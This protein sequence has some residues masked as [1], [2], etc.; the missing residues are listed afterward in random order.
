MPETTTPDPL[1]A[2]PPGTYAAGARSPVVYVYLCP[3]CAGYA[4]ISTPDYSGA[5]SGQ[6]Q[7]CGS[8]CRELHRFPALINSAARCQCRGQ[9][10]RVT[11]DLQAG[12]ER[13]LKLVARWE[14]FG[15][16][17]DAQSECA[18]ELREAISSELLG[19]KEVSSDGND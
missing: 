4:P 9:H 1:A 6:C 3:T 5:L 10:G 12:Y 16:G 7:G 18:A 13:L 2:I 11:G 19:T 14:R 15:D 17:Q 8:A